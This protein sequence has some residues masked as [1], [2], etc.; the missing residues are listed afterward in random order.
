LPEVNCFSYKYGIAQVGSDAYQAKLMAEQVGYP[1]EIIESYT[2]NFIDF[3]INNAE[4]SIGNGLCWP[5][6]ELDAWQI[7]KTK[8]VS[9]E[10]PALFFGDECFTLTKKY[11]LTNASD[12]FTSLWIY[13]FDQ[14]SFLMP[15]LTDG[16]YEMF[17]NGI[18]EDMA[19]MIPN[20]SPTANLYD[21]R[22]LLQINEI[23][24][25]W[26]LPYRESYAGQYMNVRNPLLD[27]DV[28]NFVASLPDVLQQDPSLRRDT[29]TNRY[30]KLFSIKRARSP[31]N[32]YFDLKRECEKHEVLLRKLIKDKKSRLDEIIPPQILLNLLDNVVNQPSSMPS[33]RKHLLEKLHSTLSKAHGKLFSSRPKIRPTTVA[34]TLTKM[35]ILRVALSR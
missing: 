17:A 33:S 12:I 21:T 35:L 34:N 3:I 19:A 26:L 5:C 30:P 27:N 25:N 4:L 10:S 1:F 15:F 8:V 18:A 13:S 14:L 32:C 22:H 11:L 23:H 24:S 7:L 29:V 6:S 9:I 20:D 28:L 31:G 2:G 16:I